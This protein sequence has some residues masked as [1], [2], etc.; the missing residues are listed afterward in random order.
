[1]EMA[2]NSPETICKHNQS[3]Y[4]KYQVHCRKA[5]IMEPNKPADMT[6]VIFFYSK[7]R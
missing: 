6:K 4:C 3:G 1:M 2:M 5:H 7:T